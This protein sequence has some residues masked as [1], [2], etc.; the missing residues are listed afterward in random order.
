MIDQLLT[1][2]VL[3]DLD[4]LER[5][6]AR[7]QQVCTA[8]GVQLWPHIKT[9][10]MLEVA[11]MQLAAGATGLVCAKLSEAEAMVPSGVRRLMI[12]NSLVDLRLAKRLRALHASLEELRL[13]VTSQPQAEALAGLLK[14]AG[15]RCPIMVAV[16]TGL[17]REGTRSHE[18]S[19]AVVR[20]VQQ[21]RTME[22]RGLYT[23]EGHTY[24]AA[25]DETDQHIAHVVETLAGVKDAAD[26]DL[27]LW[28]GCSVTAHR[29]AAV[30][31]VTTVR[32]GTYVF[33][34][35]SLAEK[36]QVMAWEDLAATILTTVVDR[37]SAGFALLDAGSKTLSSDRTAEGV[38]AADYDRRNIQVTRCSEEHGWTSGEDVNALRVGE[39]LRLVPAHVCPAINLH[40]EVK[41]IRGQEVVDT[42]RVDAR[43]K[44]Q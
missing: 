15:I 29:M 21:Q 16:D 23:H 44:V 18:D 41:V 27:E 33:G 4:A 40:N 35:L 36:H 24:S 32:P 31:G 20:Y 30:P 38:Y 34:D 6:V 7:M 1:P 9:H 8:H 12:A 13:A 25:R 43:G 19:L 10:K 37:P 26:A 17:G 28:P 39:R 5:N 2:S 42:W 11:R 3:I 14:A 22:L